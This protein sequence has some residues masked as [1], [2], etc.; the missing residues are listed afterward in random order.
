MT[1]L[2]QKRREANLKLRE[3]ANK[4]GVTLQTVHDTE[5]RGIR[6][7]KIAK[8]YAAIL[9]CDWR[10]LLDDGESAPSDLLATAKHS[11]DGSDLLAHQSLGGGGSDKNSEENRK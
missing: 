11:E 9:N 10:E 1:R 8:R 5:V 6:T 7:V 3:L 2:R 4:S